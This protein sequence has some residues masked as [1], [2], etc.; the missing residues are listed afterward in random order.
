[1]RRAVTAAT[2]RR[3][4]QSGWRSANHFASAARHVR[5]SI[6]PWPPPVSALAA[7][8]AVQTGS[9]DQ[10]ISV[11]PESNLEWARRGDAL[12]WLCRYEEPVATLDRAIKFDPTNGQ[13]LA[14]K[15]EVL[16]ELGNFEEAGA[17]LNQAIG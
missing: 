8:S 9:L 12:R 17:A 7:H 3:P 16:C 6:R 4:F 5:S 13:A 10:A 11:D 2:E 1:M 15:G 14:N